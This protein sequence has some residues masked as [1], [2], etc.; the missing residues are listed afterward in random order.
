MEPRAGEGT[1][2]PHA[3]SH[4]SSPSVPLPFPVST[5][6]SHSPLP[7]ASLLGAPALPPAASAGQFADASSRSRGAPG[8]FLCVFLPSA[9]FVI[10]I[11]SGGWHRQGGIVGA[12]EHPAP[13]GQSPLCFFRDEGLGRG[14][15]A[16]Q[17]APFLL[18]GR[19]WL[20]GSPTKAEANA[21]A[22]RC[23]QLHWLCPKRSQPQLG[24]RRCRGCVWGTSSSPPGR[25]AGQWGSPWAVGSRREMQRAQHWD[26][27]AP[28]EAG[29]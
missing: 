21:G 8:S 23:W 2:Q 20:H 12:A 28:R 11:V 25:G 10:M 6:G 3:W 27:L 15:A 18:S 24:S 16:S 1:L 4:L 9:Y 7:A 22:G 5:A 26:L 13:P 29:L 19:R 17:R 14:R